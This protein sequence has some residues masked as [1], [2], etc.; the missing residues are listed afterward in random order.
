[1]SIKVAQ[2]TDGTVDAG[3]ALA[4]Q[5]G[6]PALVI[7]FASPKHDPEALARSIARAFPSAATF[8]CTTAGELVSGAM[9]KGAIVAMGLGSDVVTR[10][11]VALVESV[12]ESTA[13]ID[14]AFAMWETR[15]GQK[16]LE[17][18]PERWIGLVLVDGLSGAEERVMERLGDLTNVI[19]I[20][21]SAGDDVAF[22]QTF[23]AAEGSAASGAAVVA[24]LECPEGFDVIKTQSFHATQKFLVPSKVDKA[25][26]EIIEFNGRPAAAAYAEALSVE[27]G[28]LAG[29]FMAHPLGLMV[30]GEPFVRSPQQVVG[31]S[32]RF[33]CAVDEGMKLA[34]L[35]ST[36]IVDDTASALRAAVIRNPRAKGLLNF[37]C[38]LR[39]LELEARGQTE[40]YGRVFSDI[41]TVGF[42][43]YG[44][45][46]IGHINQTATMVLFK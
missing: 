18:D 41:P 3:S 29:Q 28:D 21:G 6:D 43:T 1:M 27:P 8:G 44:E 10:S 30:G 11:E 15:L 23:V 5:L 9:T 22:K 12:A 40:A 37:N 35:D 33:Y 42:S 7:Y 13:G 39:T 25:A 34:V 32:V 24:L 36:S 14:R 31:Q 16:M 46:Y 26:R 45:E 38:I 4:A 2:L 17:L 19:F 20:G